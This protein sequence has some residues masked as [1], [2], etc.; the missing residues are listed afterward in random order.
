MGQ[1]PPRD[2]TDA[3]GRAMYQLICSRDG[4]TARE[5]ARRLGV[6][7]KTCNQRLY[8]YPFIRDL[9]YH[10]D[11]YCWHGLIQQRTPHEG[12]FE[13]SG[14]YGTV[15]EFMA[16]GEEAWLDEL[17]AGCERIGRSLN[18]TRG[19]IHS[20]RDCR[21]VMRET[22]AALSDFGVRCDGWE[23]CFEL[24][25]RRAKWVRI[26]ADVLV[27][28]PGRPGEPGRRGE[29]GYAFS[30]EFKMKDV[31]DP[32]EV[33][34]AAK[35]V[36]YLEVVLGDA[37]NVVPALVLTRAHDLYAHEELTDGGELP[38]AS[39]DALF[40]VFDEYLGFLG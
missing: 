32:G 40:N 15:A 29:S 23:L 13:F 10:D 3:L 21:A 25:I 20:F 17:R 36:P 38:V 7:R 12:L 34:Q 35:Y 26:Y 27:I 22:F 31:V 16:Q 19:L 1:R 14:W 33:A 24:R 9:C 18:D 39:G 28:V 6:D 4:I 30:L 5:M 37:V 2:A 8:T 11:D